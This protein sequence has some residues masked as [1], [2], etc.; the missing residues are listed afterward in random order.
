MMR[1]ELYDIR[2]SEAKQGGVSIRVKKD[3]R[4][5]TINQCRSDRAR[6]K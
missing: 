6:L 2:E 3:S 4:E 1:A 5:Q